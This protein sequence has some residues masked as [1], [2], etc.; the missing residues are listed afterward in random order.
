MSLRALVAAVAALLAVSVAAPLA[1]HDVP[2]PARNAA[3]YESPLLAAA[4]EADNPFPDVTQAAA[5]ATCTNGFAAGYPCSNVDLLAQLTLTDLGGGAGNDIWGWT[6][7]A[8][9]NEYAIMGMSTGTAFVDISDPE[10]PYLVGTLPTATSNSA[11]RDMKTYADHA[12]IVSEASGH[13]MQVFDLTQLRNVT[14]PPVNFA[15]T[16]RYTQFGNSHNIAINEESGFAYAVGTDTCSGG[17]HMVD[18]TTPTSPSNAGCYSGDG[19]THDVQCVNYAGPDPDYA[20][21]ELCF[22]SNEDTVTV[23]DVTSKSAPRQVSR[24]AYFGSGYTHQGW[25]TE[26]H[27]YFLLDDEFDESQYRH[28]TATYVWDV[29]NVDAPTMTGKHLGSTKAIDHNQYVLGNHS[30]QANYRAGLRILEITDAAGGSLSEVAHF[31]IYPGSDA[32]AFNGAWS[33]YPYFDSGV[34]IVSGIEQGLFVLQSTLDG[35]PPP[36]PPPPPPPN[37]SHVGDLDGTSAPLGSRGNWTAT[38]TV[39]VHDADE[40]P[41]SGVTVEG[42][43]DGRRPMSCVTGSTGTCDIEINRLRSNA[44]SVSFEITDVSADGYDAGANHDPD[45]DS[46]GTTIVVSAP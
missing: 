34:V 38:I 32:R 13:G 25:L 39:E 2:V 6:D 27:A 29:S 17:L 31:D 21:A 7:S 15:A 37:G 30:Y 23:V 4:F 10:N 12:F 42:I 40:V 1:A 33:V 5:A 46:D 45:G 44:S 14:S 28:N 18:I 19:Y 8:T 9:G 22:A 36:P 41:L 11:W 35:D 43:R 16:T 20:G 26:D 24:T 3:V